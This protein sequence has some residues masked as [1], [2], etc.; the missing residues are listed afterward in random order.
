MGAG[1]SPKPMSAPCSDLSRDFPLSPA[2][3][4]QMGWGD[5][6]GDRRP[7]VKPLP[8]AVGQF[9]RS[10]SVREE[11]AGL[12]TAAGKRPGLSR[13]VKGHGGEGAHADPGLG[14]DL[15]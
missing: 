4:L 10:S 5:L 14:R 11:L 8:L 2:L 6:G 9:S 13:E 15:E 3:S 7:G 12:L 1:G